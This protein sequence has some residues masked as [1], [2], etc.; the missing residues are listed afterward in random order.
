MDWKQEVL[1]RLDALAGKLGTTAAYPV[2]GT[3]QASG[4]GGGPAHYMDRF[5]CCFVNVGCF[6]GQTLLEIRVSR[7]SP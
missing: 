2:V 6:Y 7:L 5:P 3:C 1:K 4:D